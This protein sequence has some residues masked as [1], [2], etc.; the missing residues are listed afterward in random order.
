VKLSSEPAQRIGLKFFEVYAYGSKMNVMALR[1]RGHCEALQDSGFA[2]DFVFLVHL[3]HEVTVNYNPH[4][5]ND[6]VMRSAHNRIIDEWQNLESG[7]ILTEGS[8]E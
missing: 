3:G 6:P 7:D 5:W 1:V 4:K 8:S 2:G